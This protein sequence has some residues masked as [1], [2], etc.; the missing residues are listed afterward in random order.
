MHGL[1]V[2]IEPVGN[3]AD[4][5]RARQEAIRK[6]QLRQQQQIE[7]DRQRDLGFER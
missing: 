4:G 7:R 2:S 5:E 6:E 1:H 3:F